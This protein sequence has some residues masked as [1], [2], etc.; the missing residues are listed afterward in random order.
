MDV[1]EKAARAIAQEVGDSPDLDWKDWVGEV[2]A[3]LEAIREPTEA[4]K[5]SGEARDPN[6]SP[7]ELPGVTARNARA[8]KA[9]IDAIL[10][11]SQGV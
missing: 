11:P 9:M 10:N 6:L 4:M 2:R 8:W 3:V 7:L 5:L 1:I